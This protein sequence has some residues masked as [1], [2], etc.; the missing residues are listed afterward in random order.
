S[1]DDT[2]IA[3]T[4]EYDGNVDVY[5]V[6]A[7]GGI[8]R[9]LTCHPAPD[10]ALGWTPDGKRIVFRSPRSGF[11]GIPRLY[12]VGLDGGL[13]TELPLPTGTEASYAPEGPRLAYVPTMHWQNAWKRY[14]GGQTKPI[15]LVNLT[16][17]DVEKV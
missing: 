7:A 11:T 16:T 15:W 1:P 8:P 4:G 2:Q 13:P 3:F 6:P 17:L 9:R 10:E 5:I 14:R 12:T